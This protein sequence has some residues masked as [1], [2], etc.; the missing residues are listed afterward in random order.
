MKNIFSKNTNTDNSTEQGSD[1][2]QLDNRV[3]FWRKAVI[4]FFVGLMF[5]LIAYGFCLW[6]ILSAGNRPTDTS[7]SN[8]LTSIIDRKIINQAITKI[9]T[10]QQNFEQIASSTPILID[11]S[12]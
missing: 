8:T 10:R 1:F 2:L 12:L 3:L 11:P 5:V 4:T 9:K 7:A 6:F